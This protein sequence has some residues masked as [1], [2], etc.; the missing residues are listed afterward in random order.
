MGIPWECE[1]KINMPKMGMRME[2]VGLHV[3]MG[4][5]TFLF[6]PKFPS[7]GR[8]DSMRMQYVTVTYC[9]YVEDNT[10]LTVAYDI[11]S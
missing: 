5:A 2:R 3:T 8:L 4:M 9:T 1:H 11:L 6:V 10:T 7:I